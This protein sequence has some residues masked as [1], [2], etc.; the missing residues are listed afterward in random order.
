VVIT[1]IKREFSANLRVCPQKNEEKVYRNF[2]FNLP[3]VYPL[4]LPL[5]YQHYKEIPMKTKTW[6]KKSVFIVGTI[7]I[8]GG[9]LFIPPMLANG[10][11]KI[12][13]ETKET[14][15]YSVRTANVSKQTLSA[16]F[17]INGDIVAAQQADVFPDVAGK[18]VSVRTSL[19]SYVRKGE[20]IAEVDPSR[21]GTTYMNSPVYAPISGIVSKT[22]LSVGMTVSP[23]TSI[24]VISVSEN[25]EISA[26]IPEREIAGLTAG[27]KADVSLQ[28]YPGETFSA[29]ITRVSPILDSASRTKLINLKFDDNDSRINAGMFAR[30]RL[31]TRSYPNILAI[32]AEAVISNHSVN[33]VYVVHTNIT[34]L[35]VAARR[36]VNCGVTLQGW[37]EIKSG[38]A[39]G[40]AVIVQG[41]QLLS[42]GEGLRIIGNSIALGG[43]GSY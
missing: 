31:N 21:P 7:L 24:T 8:A 22:P 38:L 16:Y 20:L 15:V 28:A 14:P 3:Q 4:F 5:D 6:L 40:E 39:E 25:L 30:I 43:R 18:L 17:T 29:T 42:G 19:G 34:G 33:T 36:E 9:L 11:D 41:Q 1:L 2:T 26:R 32:P 12:V 10:D 35:P 37:T 13:A 27:L 23:N